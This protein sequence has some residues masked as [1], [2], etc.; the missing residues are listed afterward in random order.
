MKKITVLL[1]LACVSISFAQATDNKYQEAMLSTIEAL[2]A[3]TQNEEYQS[4][5]NKFERIALAEKNLWLPYYYASYACVLVSFNEADPGRKDIILDK[6]QLLLDS[7]FAKTTSESELYVLQAFLYPS[8]I[9][10]DPMTRGMIYVEKCFQSLE[11]AKTLNPANPRAYFLL[12]VMKLNIPESMGGGIE[13]AKACFME[14]REKFLTF[15]AENPLMPLWGEEANN[16]EL[17]KL[18]L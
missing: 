6:A 17:Q 9:M 12:G 4:C 8:R 5:A 3:A 11:T 10:V 14:A 16:S 7:A 1:I 2:N 18:G 13:V 15:K